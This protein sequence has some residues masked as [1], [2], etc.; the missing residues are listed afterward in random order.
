MYF[1]FFILGEI[2]IIHYLDYQWLHYIVYGDYDIYDDY[3]VY[4]MYEFSPLK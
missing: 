1:V 3:D 2:F 4:D